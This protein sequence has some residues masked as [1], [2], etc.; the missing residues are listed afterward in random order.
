[1]PTPIIRITALLGGLVALPA[2]AQDAPAF[3]YVEVCRIDGTSAALRLV[4]QGGAC[5]T[6]AELETRVELDGTSATVVIASKATAEMCTMQI[7]PNHVEK[8]IGIAPETSEVA[9]TLLNPQLGI[10]GQQTVPILEDGVDCSAAG[11]SF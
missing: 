10:Q 3:T 1:M 5:E 9:I 7:V 6:T 4:Y 2:L 11:E 8:V